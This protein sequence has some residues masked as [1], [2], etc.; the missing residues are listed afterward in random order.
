[1]YRRKPMTALI[2][3]IDARMVDELECVAS[4]LLAIIVAHVIGAA[5]VSWAAFSGYMVMRGHVAD[6]LS[7]GTLRIVGTIA[8]G[9]LALAATPFL[10][11]GWPLAA[12]ALMLIGTASLYAALTAK[13]AYAWLFFGLTFAMV[14]FD[15]IEHPEI[16]LGAFVETRILETV[17]GTFACMAVSLASGAT[18]RR[19]W[20]A[21]RVPRA[22]RAGWHPDALRHAVQGGAAL[23][24]LALLSDWLPLPALAQSAVT[25]MAVML[26]PASGIG[27]SGFRPVSAR[28]VQ[29]FVGCIAGAL[30][31]ALFLFTTFL[32]TPHAPAPL[33]ILGTIVGV[34]I[35]RHLENG[36]HPHRYIGTQFTLAILITVVPDSYA[37]ATIEP[38]FERLSGILIGMAVLEPILL[39][40]HFV[41]PSRRAA[42]AAT[43]PDE[44]G[45]I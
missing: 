36:D 39:A 22:Q 9:L 13:R 8:G 23:A 20:P 18:L 7:R 31:A 12:P 28:M 45:S 38:G 27:P 24:V 42:G 15:K 41:N 44:P 17:A 43:H 35:G 32:F 11:P 26:V 40:W 4:V 10:A 34:A 30:L 25:I 5:N 2:G 1:M 19:R 37:E 14:V 21:S 29:R 6:T 3:R 33:L 16:A